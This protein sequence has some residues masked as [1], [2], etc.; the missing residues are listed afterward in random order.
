[1]PPQPGADGLPGAKVVEDDA[2]GLEVARQR[3][4]IPAVAGLAKA[5]R[6]AQSALGPLLGQSLRWSCGYQR[7][8]LRSARG[9]Q[10]GEVFRANG[11]RHRVVAEPFGAQFPAR[12]PV[13]RAQVGAVERF[14]QRGQ[15]RGTV[16]QR[17]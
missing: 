9:S 1:M 14:G 2:V 7:L 6:G 16:G 3:P 5:C 10:N 15:Q 13:L 4:P 11:G 8:P 12:G 17:R